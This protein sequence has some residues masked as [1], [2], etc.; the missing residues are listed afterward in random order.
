[1][2]EVNRQKVI[3]KTSI[4]GIASNI[5]LAGF[6][7]V[8]GLL[9]NSIAI[10]LDAV[11]NT[12]DALSSIITV[13]GAK[14]AGKPADKDHPYGHG[15]YEHISAAV[16]AVIILYAG[17]ASLVESVKNIIHPE[18]PD[19]SAATFV[20]VGVAVVIKIFL[21][22]YFR[23]TGK[24]VESDALVNS[25][26]DA[27]QDAVISVSTIVAAVIFLI[28]GLSLEAYLGVIIS[29]F[30]IKAGIE[31]IRDTI[32]KLLGERADKELSDAVKK[33]VCETEGVLGAYDLILN[34]YG[35]GRWLASVHITVPDTWTATKIDTVSR[36]IMHNVA[37]KNQVLV[38]A[39]G[40]YSHNTGSDEIA[41]IR[42]AVAEITGSEEFVIQMH[43]FFCDIEKKEI[44]FD[45]VI[46]FKAPDNEKLIENI[47]KKVR[48]LY[49]E[50]NVT[51][52][53]DADFTD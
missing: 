8:V 43:G 39:V 3:V 7:A 36:E 28:W 23:K 18:T 29:G 19:Y 49:P 11:N 51:I 6:K 46:D 5:L 9:S 4:I 27:L 32:S 34:S 38:T 17:I 22:L 2:A 30:I 48:A 21:G 52:Q 47:R 1:M 50:Y 20:V 37:V 26:T 31:M 35:P 53:P 42:T 13:I 25:G 24:S 44:R 10:V 40:I 12:S 45:I 33:T 14:L 41:K 15:R 16:I